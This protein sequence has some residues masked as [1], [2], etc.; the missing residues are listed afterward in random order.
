[1]A[2]DI[3]SLGFDVDSSALVKAR[4][5]LAA[6][7]DAA[8]KTARPVEDVGTAAQRAGAGVDALASTSRGVEAGLSSVAMGAGAAADAFDR[9]GPAS[10]RAA[11]GV[12]DIIARSTG[13]AAA[14]RTASA[15]TQEWVNELNR[16]AAAFD[17][18]RASVDPVFAA[19]KRY[20]AAVEGVNAAVQAGIVTQQEANRVLNLAAEAHLGVGKAVTT[21]GQ[22]AGTSGG[23]FQ[24]YGSQIQNTSYQLQDMV[25]QISMG[26]DAIRAMSM[27]LPQMLGGFGAWGALV[28]VAVG[29]LGGL[30]PMLLS[31]ADGGRKLSDV[32]TDLAGAQ[33]AYTDAADLSRTSLMDLAAEFGSSAVQARE[34]Y[35]VLR[36]LAMLELTQKL[37]QTGSALNSTFSDM[38]RWL[39]LNNTALA[40]FNAGLRDEAAAMYRQVIAGLNKEFGLTV[41]QAQQVSGALDQINRAANA[42]EQAEGFRQLATVLRDAA[43]NGAKIPPELLATATA[44]GQAGLEALR[45]A[46]AIAQAS[47]NTGAAIDNTNSWAAAMSGVAAQINAIAS[48]ISAI[49]GG[50]ISRAAMFVE[51]NALAAG[52]SVAQARVEVEK[53]KVANE[54]DAQIMGARAKGGIFGAVAAKALEAAK[55]VDLSNVSMAAENVILTQT[56]QKAERAAGAKAKKAK[57]SKAEAKATRDLIGELNHELDAR[58]A[59]IGLYGEERARVEALQQVQSKLGKDIDKY[60]REAIQAAAD[61][62]VAVDKETK[63]WEDHVNRIDGLTDDLAGAWGDWIAGGLRD[64]KDFAGN[65]LKSF[66]R[67]ISEM[68]ATAAANPIRLAIT[69]AMGGFGG[70]GGAAAGVP[71]MG[72]T[73][74]ILGGIGKGI[75]TAISGAM[76]GFGSVVSGLF[77]GGLGGAAGALTTALGGATSGLAGLATAAGAIAPPLAAAAAV[78]SFFKSKTKELDRGLR[79]TVNGMDAVIEQYRKTEKSR[80]WGLS[81][82]RRTSYEDAPAEIADP[83]DSALDKVQQSVLDAAKALNVGQTAFADF[84]YQFKL[85]TKDM[86]DAEA[87]EAI[88]AEIAKFGDAYAAMIPGIK[89]YQ[90]EGEGAAATLSRLSSS[91][92]VVNGALGDLGLSL[93][94]A[95]LSGAGAAASFADLFG[96]LDAFQQASGAYYQAFYT[97]QERLTRLRQVSQQA[98]RDAGLAVPATREAYRQL[99]EAQNLSTEAGRKAA[100][101]L[102]QL[103]PAFDQI[104]D[105]AEAAKIALQ[106]QAAAQRQAIADANATRQNLLLDLMTEQQ[107]AAYEQQRITAVFAEMGVQVPKTLEGLQAIIKGLDL[108]GE[109]GRK[110]LAQIAGIADALKDKFKP[111]AQVV[112]RATGGG[113]SGRDNVASEREQLERQLLQLQGNITELRRRELD[114]LNPANRALQEMVWRL[115][116]AK[117]AMDKFSPDQFATRVEY[118]L[119]RNRQANINTAPAAAAD[120]KAQEARQARDSAVLAEMRDYSLNM[121]NEM[122]RL[123]R[124]TREMRMLQEGSAA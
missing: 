52:K 78:F 23:I 103:A 21:A 43:A 45:T 66:Q 98:I 62:I 4:T 15:S 38:Q 93:Y 65:I 89:E 41:G 18:L 105:A 37:N 26:T 108:T 73:G 106:E 97:E 124:E 25:V 12:Q 5:D 61:R 79:V 28:G 48:A 3:V 55:A 71:G 1:M 9:L 120:R 67:M 113:S 91:L 112:D 84:A 119:A 56:A 31:A 107:R 92:S 109:A 53:F 10:T 39:D 63:A 29:V 111:V 58:E 2:L 83:I 59:L 54:W 60:S 44:A 123:V 110:A 102:I 13:L 19:S 14:A 49:G 24:R 8:G 95:S 117:A 90:K 100:A 86:T 122:H 68:I 32:M 16:Q 104:Y 46:N 17:T 42:T 118:E 116:D 57:G 94:Q 47:D 75:G 51:R 121:L 96:S 76:S 87:L 64:F 88:Q 7:A 101:V 22:V 30:A 115:E 99:V 27:Q 34:M 114:A 81:K 6:L 11:I 82:K 36:D 69:G 20:E 70:A 50:M 33:A 80:F 85:S 74:G 72:G 35:N 40:A 77:S